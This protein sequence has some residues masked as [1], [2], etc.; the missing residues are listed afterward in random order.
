MAAHL[1]PQP[2]CSGGS[3]TLA[4]HFN[5][6]LDG[7]WFSGT[8]VAVKLLERVLLEVRPHLPRNGT[9]GFRMDKLLYSQELNER[10]EKLWRQSLD[11]S[12]RWR[13]PS[14]KGTLG[15][16]FGCPL[17]RVLVVVV[18]GMASDACHKLCKRL[19]RFRTHRFLGALVVDIEDR[20]HQVVYLSE[21]MTAIGM[22]RPDG[23]IECGLG[24]LEY[25][26]EIDQMWARHGIG[27]YLSR[28][29]MNSV[30]GLLL[31]G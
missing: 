29:G 31:P 25:S 7:R 14:H 24:C 9:V 11:P 8:P 13:G 10:S 17:D 28:G 15:G 16:D 4:L 20:I 26:P 6:S 19:E 2:S 18:S 30:L 5:Y 3:I 23:T 12:R 21:R 1:T 22:L 27:S